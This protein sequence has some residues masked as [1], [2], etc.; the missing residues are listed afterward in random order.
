MFARQLLCGV[1]VAFV[2][3]AAPAAADLCKMKKDSVSGATLRAGPCD[4]F[5]AL[6]TVTR[7]KEAM[8][9][10]NESFSSYECSTTS[11]FLLLLFFF[12]FLC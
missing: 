8:F 2:L 12:E 5:P 1:V 10:V 9:F 3:A 11:A 4:S 7:A 6:R